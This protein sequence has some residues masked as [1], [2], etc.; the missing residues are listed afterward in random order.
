MRAWPIAL[1]LSVD[2]FMLVCV[3]RLDTADSLELPRPTM[4]RA[5]MVSIRI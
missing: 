1:V 2:D 5:L 4:H 3:Q